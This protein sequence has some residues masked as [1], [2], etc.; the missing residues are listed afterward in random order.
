PEGTLVVPTFTYSFCKR[1]PFDP[2]QTPST[3]GAFTDYV[4]CQPGARRS[5]DP[6][7]SVA[8]LGA[9]AEELTAEVPAE[10]F[11][12]N[13]FWDR[14]LQADGLVCNLNFDAGSTFIHFVERCLNVPYRYD[15]LFTGTF[16]RRGHA[17]KGAAIY[18]C[19]DLSNAQTAAAFEPFD[20]LAREQGLARTVRVGRGA[21]LGIRA[22]E[23]YDLIENEL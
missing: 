22:A 9:R 2:D 8:A 12:Q 18:F 20:T 11:G 14:F 21:V 5:E 19:Q 17:S 15:K 4:R 23:T 1:E 3:C 16:V 7:F 6:I 13:S 10:C